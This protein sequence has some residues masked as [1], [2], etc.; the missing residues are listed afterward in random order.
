[1]YIKMYDVNFGEAIIYDNS[2]SKL[3]VDCGAKFGGR[4][5]LAY[6][7]IADDFI[8]GRDDILIT[9]FDEDH[10]NGLIAM[11]KDHRKVRRIYLPKY[12]VTDEG[13]GY[14]DN[15]F[16]DRL[17][18]IMYLYLL[19]KKDRLD[20]LQELFISIIALAAP[21]FDI[22]SVA[23]GDVVSVGSSQFDILWPEIDSSINFD[24]LSDRIRDLFIEAMSDNNQI[25]EMVDGIIDNYIGVFVDFYSAVNGLDAITGEI[26]EQFE[27]LRTRF[28]VS[29]QQLE[30]AEEQI[31]G[32]IPKQILE[33][34]KFANASL[35]KRQNNCS[36]VFSCGKTILALGDV[37]KDVVRRLKKKGRIA[38]QYNYIK[39]PH[40]GTNRH[41]GV[42][43]PCAKDA[44][45]I[46]NS[47]K[48]REDDWTIS[49][50]YPKKYG[51]RVYCT[52]TNGKRCVWISKGNRCCTNCNVGIK[53]ATDPVRIFVYV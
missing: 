13:V 46:S 3:L 20:G 19:G 40:H 42:A 51:N 18:A 27:Q 30:A 35:L 39:A 31:Q 50:K 6:R 25:I 53:K 4:G 45:F 44:V 26:Q 22:R 14:T 16:M 7:A 52:N 36:V 23:Y 21:K 47:G 1:M 15:E 49:Y 17:R 29:Y 11:A 38:K 10:Y 9:H 8:F 2:N 12:V 34:T 48:W 43:L 33:R 24:L 32:M 41:M 37:H 28:Y 5:E